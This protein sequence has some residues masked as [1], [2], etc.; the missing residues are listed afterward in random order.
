M[1]KVSY[2]HFKFLPLS[3]RVLFSMVLLVFGLGYCMAMVQVWESH[4]GKD[5]NPMLSAKD[6]MISYSGNPEG[7]RLETALRGPMADML[8]A[9][10]KQKIFAW[11]HAKAPQDQFDSTI[12]P[13]LQEHCVACHN[14]SAN[15]NLPNLTN[16]D[17]VSKVAAADTGMTIATLVRVSHIHLFSITFIFFITGYIFTHS[18]IRPA[19]FKCVV[20]A[21]PFLSLIVDVAA[22]YLTKLWTGFAWAVIIGGA[23]YG[24][25]FT[26]MWFTSMYQ[27]WLYKPSQDLIDAQGRL[28]S[29]SA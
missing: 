9:E 16:F 11:L 4:A 18:Y 3:V 25:C 23:L 21:T 8:D 14:P 29:V 6:L 20:L 12:G 15:P 2:V 10:N 1:T 28:P 13:I 22:W 17:G 5:G 27:M 24:I 19:W 26:I 7:T